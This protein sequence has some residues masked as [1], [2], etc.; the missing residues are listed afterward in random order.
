MTDGFAVVDKAAGPTSHD[1]VAQARRRFGTRKVGH[2]GTLDP[3]ATGVLVLGVGRATRLLQFLTGLD[4]SY[5]AEIQFGVET[6]TLDA[7]SEVTATHDMGPLDAA[8]VRA[9]VA[10]FL[11]DIQQVPPMVSA[12]KVEGRR[13]HELAREGK[14]VERQPRQVHVARFDVEP[15]DIDAGRWRAVIDCSSGTYVRSL[16]A[17]L[18]TALG[19]GAHVRTLR[20]TAVGSFTLAQAAPLDNATIRPPAAGLSHLP[21]VRVADDVAVS[22]GHGRVLRPDELGVDGDGPWVVLDGGGAV[23]AVYGPHKETL[24]KPVMVLAP[25]PARVDTE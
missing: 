13:L 18:G 23:L 16:A 4:K 3:D 21:Q 1:V 15:V 11:G 5:E 9:A 6:S 7:A 12:I 10:G 25:A 22:V 20:R 19:G 24:V 2:A 17:D 14:E 8:R